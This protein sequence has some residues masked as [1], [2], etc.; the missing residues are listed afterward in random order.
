MLLLLHHSKGKLSG[1]PIRLTS[2]QKFR[3][4]QLYGWRH[5]DT[6]FKRFKKAFTEVGRKNAKSQMEA[7]EALNEISEQADQ[8]QRDL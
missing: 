6:G 1:Q 2:W 5:K 3:E 4:C 7:G 8:E